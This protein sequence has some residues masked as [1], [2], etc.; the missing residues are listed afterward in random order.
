MNE[1][2]HTGAA[3]IGRRWKAIVNGSNSMNEERYSLTITGDI[4]EASEGDTVID[5]LRSLADYIE[6]E[7]REMEIKDSFQITLHP[8]G[9]VT[10]YAQEA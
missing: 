2:M 3:L 10:L 5:V 6:E 1:Q 9:Y 8:P 7:T 4:A